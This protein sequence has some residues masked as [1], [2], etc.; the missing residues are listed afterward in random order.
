ME[1]LDKLNEKLDILLAWIKNQYIKA[2]DFLTDHRNVKISMIITVIGYHAL[3]IIG[4]IIAQFNSDFSAI[5]GYNIWD[6]WISDLGGSTFTPMPIFY[7][8]AAC[9]AGTL[10]IPLTFFIEKTVASVP[11]KLEELHQYSRW[12]FRFASYGFLFGLIGNVGYIFVGLFSADRNYWGLHGIASILSFGGFVFAGFFFGL[13]IVFYKTSI[14]RE[15][16]IYMIIVPPLTMILYQIL[17]A[18][19]PIS[20]PFME[21]MLLFSILAWVDPLCI[22]TIRQFNKEKMLQKKLI[23]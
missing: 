18:Y 21:W 15:F 17:P 1:L 12:R 7:D 22:Y 16:G 13:C 9:L 20:N 6:N 8:L 5:D 19:T 4:V 3:L 23:K 10:T 11:S 2:E 14:P